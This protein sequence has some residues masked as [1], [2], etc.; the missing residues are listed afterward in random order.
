M[1]RCSPL[2][3]NDCPNAIAFLRHFRELKEI[4]SCQVENIYDGEKEGN[5]GTGMV[6]LRK[7]SRV[8]PA[9]IK[10]FLRLVS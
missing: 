2:K 1:L 8:H 3:R 10:E 5:T 9:G 4:T 7:K 6:P